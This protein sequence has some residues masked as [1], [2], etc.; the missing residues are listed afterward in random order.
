MPGLLIT[1]EGPEGAGK[2]T[3]LELLRERLADRAVEVY[4][5]P[6]STRLGDR[7]RELLLNGEA[8]NP[9]A[10]MFLFM[11]ARAELI[12]ERILPALD[13]GAIVLLDRYHDS[14][15]AYQGARGARTFWP[16]SFPRPALTVLL[17][18]DPRLGLRRQRL[19][20][21]APDRI[22]SEPDDFHRRVAAEYDRLAAAEPERFLVVDAD[23]PAEAVAERIWERVSRLLPVAAR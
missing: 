23:Q 10:E 8:M 16:E 1:L 7:V 21:K 22:E 19:A 6:G 5:E 3:Q 4:R 18:A 17:R 11:G 13:R 9:E 12:G 14:T 20:G 15:L 2:S